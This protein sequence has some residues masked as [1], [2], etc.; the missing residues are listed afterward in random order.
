MLLVS[1]NRASDLNRINKTLKGVVF[2]KDGSLRSNLQG[3]S[4]GTSLDGRG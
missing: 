2:N 1:S 4:G 3:I